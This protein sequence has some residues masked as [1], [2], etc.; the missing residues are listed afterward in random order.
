M[1]TLGD[2]L[3]ALKAALKLTDDVKALSETV[4]SFAEEVR[5]LDRRTTRVEARLDTIMDF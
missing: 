4:K 1:S 2:A 5:E 3:A